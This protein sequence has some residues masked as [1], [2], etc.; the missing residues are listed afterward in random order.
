MATVGNEYTW[1]KGKGHGT[2]SQTTRDLGFFC[3]L[4]PWT[5]GVTA[6][7]TWLTSLTTLPLCLL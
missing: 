3:T 7:P 4:F 6:V 2:W 5:L 1:S